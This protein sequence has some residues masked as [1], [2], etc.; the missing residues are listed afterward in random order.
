[1]DFE[2]P[3]EQTI[4]KMNREYA[5]ILQKVSPLS[6]ENNK[7][8]INDVNACAQTNNFFILYFIFYLGYNLGY[9]TAI[10]DTDGSM[11]GISPFKR[12]LGGVHNFRN[13]KR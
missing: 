13:G 5:N 4:E 11:G 2:L 10:F 9:G 12:P 1:M 8:K 7:V 3:D 6:A